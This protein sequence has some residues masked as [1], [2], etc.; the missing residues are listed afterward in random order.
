MVIPVAELNPR[1]RRF[2]AEYLVDLKREI[3]DAIEGMENEQHKLL[4]E[5]RYFCGST[6]EQI[7]EKMRIDLRWVYRMHGRALQE[8]TF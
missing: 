6:W 1:Q 5:Y 8:I 2:V 3:G 4:L 7:A